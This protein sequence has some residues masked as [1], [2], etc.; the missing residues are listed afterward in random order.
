MDASRPK[1]PE[2]PIIAYVDDDDSVREALGGMLSAFGFLNEGYD[3]AEVLLKSNCFERI[4]CLITDVR[5]GGMSG[6]QLQDRLS[7]LGYRIPVI[8]I[9][10]HADES[11]RAKAL[12]GGAVDVL[13]KPIV[14]KDLLSA[15]QSS[16][17]PSTQDTGKA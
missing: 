16:L 10:A 7:E 12:R 5:L 8:V 17:N 15:I 1:V 13:N 2:I 14:I 4:A 6:L 3:S 9:T 11:A